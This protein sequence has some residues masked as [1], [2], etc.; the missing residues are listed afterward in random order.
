MN[1]SI[2]TSYLQ[3]CSALFFFIPRILKGSILLARLCCAVFSSAFV[4][5]AIDCLSRL[6]VQTKYLNVSPHTFQFTISIC[7]FSCFVAGKRQRH[8]EQLSL[9]RNE[10]TISVSLMFPPLNSYSNTHWLCVNSLADWMHLNAHYLCMF[11]EWFPFIFTFL[12]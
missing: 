2:Q 7:L 4:L 11:C 9:P 1:K 5:V 3:I 8:T 12:N 6:C 10:S